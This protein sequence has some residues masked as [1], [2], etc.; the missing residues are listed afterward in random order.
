MT[1]DRCHVQLSLISVTHNVLS[2]HM[3]YLSEV[4]EYSRL[5]VDAARDLVEHLVK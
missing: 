2:I 3:A 1:G 5:Y 4:D